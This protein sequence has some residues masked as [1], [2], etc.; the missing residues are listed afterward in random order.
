MSK[1]K[2]K[3]EQL[4]LEIQKMEP[5]KIR[6]LFEKSRPSEEQAKQYSNLERSLTRSWDISGHRCP[7]CNGMMIINKKY[8]ECGEMRCDYIEKEFK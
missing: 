1:V 7:V 4:L 6:E 8:H 3:L 5:S 2:D